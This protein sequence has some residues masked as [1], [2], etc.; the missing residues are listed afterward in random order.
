MKRIFKIVVSL[1]LV[2]VVSTFVFA[3]SSN[4]FIATAGTLRD[5]ADNFMDVRYFNEVDFSNFFTWLDL[6]LGDA[7]LGFAKKVKELYFGA[8]YNGNLWTGNTKVDKT[9]IE[10]T[11]IQ[12]DEGKNSSNSFDFIFGFAGMAVKLDTNFELNDTLSVTETSKDDNKDSLYSFQLTWG[13]LSIPLGKIN[14]RPYATL[15]FSVHNATTVNE[16]KIVD[17]IYTITDKQNNVNYFDML[18][19]SDVEWG[20]KA[21]FFSVAGLGY[22][23]DLGI[24]ANGLVYDN[25]NSLQKITRD[26]AKNISNVINTYYRFEYTASEKVKFGAKANLSLLINTNTNG[27]TSTKIGELDPV[28][29][30]EDV[31]T[32]TNFAS[33]IALGMQYKFKPEFAMNVGF[34]T[35]FPYT[36][37]DK[38]VTSD[39][40]TV[41][42]YTSTLDT[43][44]YTGFVW[45]I[46]ENCALDTSMEIGISP[47]FLDDILNGSL[48]L[49][50]KY[51]M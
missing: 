9:D 45:D 21:G 10:G 1:L 40:V 20:D 3:Q 8:Y 26:G 31:N 44:L 30:V 5:D 25:T 18:L 38:T 19:A 33:S 42:I 15:G 24:K 29:N 41:N 48:S 23:L 22:L 39:T 28:T 17:T 32:Y 2:L 51:K 50:F 7:N 11:L 14:L 12:Y 43:Y 37:N 35:S 34:Y 49:G 46:N 27:V 47:K 13:G 36:T 16:E 4:T 6:S